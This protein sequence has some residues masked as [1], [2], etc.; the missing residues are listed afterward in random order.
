MGKRLLAAALLYL[1]L[2]ACEPK[3]PPEIAFDGAQAQD[4]GVVRAHGERL[5][6]VL[7]C[8]SCHGVRL[9]GAQFDPQMKQYGPIY[10]SN[11]SLLMPHYSDAE[12]DAIV[13]R[14][15]H[16]VRRTVWVM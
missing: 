7:G 1:G 10:A 3:G 14:G 15:T 16:P 5:T 9:E 6:H 13:R 8:T 2:A 11:L 12:L 4:A